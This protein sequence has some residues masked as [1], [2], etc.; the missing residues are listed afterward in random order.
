MLDIRYPACS[1]LCETTT[2][3]MEIVKNTCPYTL[4]FLAVPF[5]SDDMYFTY[6]TDSQYLLDC[7]TGGLYECYNES[8]YDGYFINSP[9]ILF[10]NLTYIHH[11][12]F[13]S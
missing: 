6:T 5:I 10:K 1:Q 13:P 4:Y 12:W 8:Y 11:K 3:C 2:T 9:K 7:R